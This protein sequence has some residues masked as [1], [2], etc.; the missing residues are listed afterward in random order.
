MR[1]L[2]LMAGSSGSGQSTQDVSSN[3][4]SIYE[5][6]SPGLVSP[7]VSTNIYPSPRRQVLY[8]WWAVV[9]TVMDLSLSLNA[10]NFLTLEGGTDTLSHNVSEGLPLD[11]A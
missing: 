8:K 4:L 6:A 1:V 5:F 10:G 7:I 11:A 9:N 2:L 3:T